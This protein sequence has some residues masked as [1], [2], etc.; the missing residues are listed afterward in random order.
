MNMNIDS[1]TEKQLKTYIEQYR[2]I[3]ITISDSLFKK[4]I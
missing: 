2:Y 1:W 4:G 3:I